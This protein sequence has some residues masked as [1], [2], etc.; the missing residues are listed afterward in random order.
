[1][2]LHSNTLKTYTVEFGRDGRPTLAHIVGRLS[3]S[4]HRFLANHGDEETL[5]RLASRSEEP[6]GKTGRVVPDSAGKKGQRRN[7]FY[8]DSNARL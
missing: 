8:L 6:I 2:D 1:M 4:N 7:L 3:G 5:N